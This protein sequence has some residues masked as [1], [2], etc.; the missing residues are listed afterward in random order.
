MIQNLITVVTGT[1]GDSCG[2][3]NRQ[4]FDLR[5][6]TDLP[7]RQI[8][9]DDGTIDEDQKE[10]Q[11][12][13]CKVH[14]PT[15]TKTP[16]QWTENPG[17]PWGISYNLN[18]ALGMVETPWAFLVEDGLRPGMGWLETAVDAIRQIG[19]QEWCGHK[20]GMMG[21]A[22][23]EDWHLAMA[24]V[25]PSSMT[26]QEFCKRDYAECYSAFWGS[27]R[28]PNWNDGLWCWKRMLPALRRACSREESS[29]WPPFVKR[30]QEIVLTGEEPEMS[31]A[32]GLCPDRPWPTRRTGGPAWFPAAFL[33]LNMDAW[34]AVGRM[35]DGCTFFEGHLGIRMA[36][37][38]YLSLALEFPPWLHFPGMGFRLGNDRAA[39]TPRHHEAC[40]GDN[41]K[42]IL[43]RDFGCNGAGHVDVYNLVYKTFPQDLQDKITDEMAGVTLWMHP[44]WKRWL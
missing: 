32:A 21:T 6:F 17:N 20:V 38:G 1:M 9:S 23:F 2:H 36:Q 10:R 26:F 22:S 44:A 37:H 39:K 30:F 4:A 14:S 5:A 24:G 29:S 42:D 15:G 8:V 28:H 34:R 12:G 18:H 35:R 33:I 3:I 31:Y 27:A 40:D 13:I 25:L 16:M 43:Y 11:R 41:E 19:N 7:F